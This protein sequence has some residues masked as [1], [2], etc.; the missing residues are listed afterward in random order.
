MSLAMARVAKKNCRIAL[1]S[2]YSGR[3]L[4]DGAIQ[5]ALIAALQ[6]AD[7]DIELVGIT[8]DPARTTEIHGI[9]CYR[10]SLA[11]GRSHGLLQ[12]G[13]NAIRGCARAVQL[14]RGLDLLLIAGGGQL[15]EEWGGAW[16]QPF[17]LWRWASLAR[18]CR[19]PVAFASVGLG[20]LESAW[21]RSLVA[22]ALNRACYRSYR[23]SGT[24][25]LLA[26]LGIGH[27]DAVVPDIAFSLP[28]ASHLGGAT[29]HGPIGVS[30]ISFGHAELWA[31]PNMQVYS[32][33]VA[34]L[35][36]FISQLA[37]QDE[38]VVLFVTSSA[39]L[40]AADDVVRS[41]G[42]PPD[43]AHRVRIIRD[44][45]LEATL[46]VMDSCR[47]IVASRLHGVILSQRLAKPLLAVSFDRKVDA[48]MQQSGMDAYRCDI[49]TFTAAEL[50]GQFSRL[51]ASGDDVRLRLQH[52]V[53]TA[54]ASLQLQLNQLLELTSSTTARTTAANAGAPSG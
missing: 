8:A 40:A 50:M 10:L 3:N 39:D 23:D 33:Y 1:L 48:Q 43:R 25:E 31:R 14:L 18:L 37:Q 35:G 49:R 6:H 4:G 22:G 29:A 45:T 11:I 28:L 21:G 27:D 38:E 5:S 36:R 16:G 44:G 19:C 54:Q 32:R 51:H 53:G 15:D 42:L 17:D 34:E 30:P 41:A 26:P 2:P 47:L 20:R 7:P 13:V 12:T 24:R 52:Y 46:P 9:P